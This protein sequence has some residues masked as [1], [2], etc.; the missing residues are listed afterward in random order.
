IVITTAPSHNQVV[1]LLWKEINS[2]FSRADLPGRCLTSELKIN[3]DHF[4][5]GISPKIEVADSTK[6][7]QGYHSENMLI[8]LD[9]ASG[10]DPKIFEAVDF[11]T[12][13]VNC[14]ILA[15]G[16]PV[17]GG[18]FEKGFKDEEIE[19][20]TLSIFESENFIINDIKTL[21]DLKKIA[22]EVKPLNRKERKEY[23]KKFKVARPYLTTV[24][25]AVRRLLDWGE[26][27][28]LF[29]SRVL[30][31]FPKVGDDTVLSLQ[32][33]EASAMIEL[34]ESSSKSLGVDVAR[35]GSDNTVLIG[36]KNFKQIHKKKFNGQDTVKTSNMIKHLIITEDYKTIVIDDTG[37][38]GAITDQLN[39]W[40]NET[41][42]IVEIIPV[43]FAESAQNEDDYS[44][45]VTEMWFNV[46]KLI[47]EKRIQLIDDGNLFSELAGRKY[48]FDNKG[49]FKVESKQEYKKRNGSRSP[50]EADA[51]ILCVWGLT[52]HISSWI[53]RFDKTS[54]I[55]EGGENEDPCN[56]AEC[57]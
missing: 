8:I 22:L 41:N 46:K 19:K 3:D 50:D 25:W 18:E 54:G 49:R 12:T 52:D 21:D 7:M 23:F 45:I 1:K 11:L 20:I 2:S 4:A 55:I 57:Y 37:I 15:I 10:I 31:R 16:N 27:N 47:G 28:P 33:L 51:L 48:D 38:G 56:P 39:D 35:F 43:N 26:T 24:E 14:K 9:E 5:L 53:N 6:R 34:T 17:P 30:G 42:R 13:S 29:I 36:Y 32:D 44:G 40:V